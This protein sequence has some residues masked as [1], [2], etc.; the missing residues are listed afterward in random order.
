LN[1]PGIQF[2]SRVRLGEMDS[3]QFSKGETLAENTLESMLNSQI[4]KWKK[5]FQVT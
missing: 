1:D 3:V 2:Y 5:D 4:V